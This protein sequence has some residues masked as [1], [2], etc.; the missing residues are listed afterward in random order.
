MEI[1]YSRDELQRYFSHA[2]RVSNE[3][4]VLLDR[5]LSDAIEVDV[6][7]VCD[8]REVMIGGVMEHIE[9]A[10]VHSGD[11][12]CVLP[13]FSLSSDT[14]TEIRRQSRE[15]ALALGVV[16][17]MNAQFAVKNGDI[18]VLEVN[19]RASR[20]VPFVSKATS[21]PLAKIAARCMVGESL[22]EQGVVSTVTPPYFSLKEAVFP[23]VKFPGVDLLLGPEMKS[24]GG[25]MGVGATLGEAFDKAQRA[26]GMFIPAT[27]TVLISVKTTDQPAVVDVA[28]YL[29]I[30]GFRLMAT[31]GTAETLEAAGIPSSM[32]RKV[33][34]AHPNVADSIRDDEFDLI[35][36]TTASRPSR[37]DSQ[38]IRRLAL[39]Y[40]V[41]YYTTLASARAA[42]EAHRSSS[43]MLVN[44]LQSLHEACVYD[45]GTFND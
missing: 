16:G 5:F 15:L 32:I 7:V 2:I 37:R 42:C 24:T 45:T 39:I 31:E 21:R 11:S 23:F 35:I 20:T 26:A 1:V 38:T 28:R 22:A 29:S 12:A 18:Y 4:P 44:R 27:G 17:L 10:G 6:D 9:E 40:K 43:Q 14:Q 30:N 8:G 3:S 33:S 36:N 25:V 19:P 13:P 34:E 41:P